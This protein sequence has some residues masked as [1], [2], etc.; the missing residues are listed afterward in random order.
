MIKEKFPEA[1][2]IAGVATA[3]IPQGAL[4]ADELNL[5]YM[6]VRP[7]PKSHGMKNCIE[8][9]LI[10]NQKVVL[11]EDLISTGGSSIK[12]AE[13]LRKEGGNPVGIVAIFSYQFEEAEKN[14]RSANIPFYTLSDYS[15][16]IEVALQKKIIREKEL[17]TLNLW[18]KN[19]EK[20]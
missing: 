11:A 3:G 13:N 12:A 1:E 10:D 8:G 5:P 2:A 15:T 20:W 19:P 18:R 9:K 14:A 6:Y 16:L 17:E 4:V 7:T